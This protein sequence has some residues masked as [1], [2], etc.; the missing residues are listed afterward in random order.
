MKLDGRWRRCRARSLGLERDVVTSAGSDGWLRHTP[1][2]ALRVTLS[3]RLADGTTVALVAYPARVTRTA[4][5]YRLE[6]LEGAG[7]W[8]RLEPAA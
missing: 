6:A 7:G 8:Q 5:G 2:L 3:G 1:G 4:L